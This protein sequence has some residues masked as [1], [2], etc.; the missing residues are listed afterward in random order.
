MV[1]FGLKLRHVALVFHQDVVDQPITQEVQQLQADSLTALCLG[2]FLGDALHETAVQCDMG[3]KVR[4]PDAAHEG[5]FF[6]EV[7]NGIA[8]QVFQRA[9]DRGGIGVAHDAFP[10]AVHDVEEHLVL[11]VNLLQAEGVAVLP[12]HKRCG[13]FH[14]FGCFLEDEKIFRGAGCRITIQPV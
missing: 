12:S 13:Q 5:F 7:Q 6:G 2:L 10:D 4:V 8:F 1:L 3:I 14:G 9:A 11:F